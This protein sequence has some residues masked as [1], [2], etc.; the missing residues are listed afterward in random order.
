MDMSSVSPAN[1]Y[2]ADTVALILRM[3]RRKMGNAARTVFEDAEADL[4]TIYVPSFTLA[5]ILYLSEK[6]RIQTTLKDVTSYLA[7]YPSI[8]EQPLDNAIISV[9]SE[10][11]DVNELHDRLIAATARYY[12]VPLITNDGVLSTSKFVQTIWE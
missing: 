12:N 7:R 9:A 6:K 2:A 10:I 5:E 11:T 1:E 3:E 8:R 4:A